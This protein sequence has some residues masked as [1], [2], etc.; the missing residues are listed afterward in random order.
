M[1]GGPIA[2]WST[3]PPAAITGEEARLDQ[4][5]RPLYPDGMLRFGG[6]DVVPTPAMTPAEGLVYDKAGM[7]LMVAE[8]FNVSPSYEYA[9]AYQRDSVALRTSGQFAVPVPAMAVRKLTVGP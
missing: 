5:G 1:P 3:L 2:T 7:Y 8:D 9:P 4:D 6:L